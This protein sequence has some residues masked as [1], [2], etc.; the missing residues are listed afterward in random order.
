MEPIIELRIN[1]SIFHLEEDRV[2]IN[3]IYGYSLE[4]IDL[5]N[6]DITLTEEQYSQVNLRS[7]NK[8][9]NE[10]TITDNIHN[11]TGLFTYTGGGFE[12][13]RRLYNI[14]GVIECLN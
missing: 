9:R 6:I 7:G 1:E 11:I 14:K 3:P 4:G 8:K 5:F 10:I 2:R 12:S 13:F